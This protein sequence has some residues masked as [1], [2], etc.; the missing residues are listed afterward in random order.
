MI[1]LNYQ[2]KLKLTQ[3]QEKEILVIMDVCKDVYNFALVD[4]KDWLNSR[5]CFINQCSLLKEYIIPSDAPYPNYIIQSKNLTEAKKKIPNLK[6]ANAQVLQQTLKTLDKAFQDMKAKGNGFPRFKKKLRSFVFPSLPNNC[7]AD[8]KVKVPQ[9]GWLVIRQSRAYPEGF[10][11]KTARIIK[12]ASGYYLQICFQSKEII[13]DN[14]IGNTSLGIDAGIETFVATSNGE[15]IKA[16]RFLLTSLRQIKLLQKRFKHMKK[17]SNKWL[18]LQGKIARIHETVANIRKDWHYKLAHHLCDISDNIFVEDINFKSWSR[19]IVRKRSLDS[20]IGA[21]I[22]Q[23]LPFVT[24]KRG[25]YFLKVNKNGTSQEC[26]NCQQLTG[27][28]PLNQRSH[29]CR[30]CG[31][32]ESRDIAASKVILNRGLKAVGHIV[33]KNAPG[34]VLTG[35]NQITLIDLVKIQ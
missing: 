35:I 30:F 29:N 25:K 3:K 28:K 15:L 8:N 27:K 24:W 22:N 23:I 21:F 1:T 11:P 34:E 9:L 31:H 5:K 12:K 26:P 2:F 20:G 14:P 19:G 4:R 7:L 16:P 33:F 10:V 13:P 6:L 32:I 18:K 17:G